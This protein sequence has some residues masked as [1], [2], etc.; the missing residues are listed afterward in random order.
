MLMNVIMIMAVANQFVLI[1]PV[2]S[3]VIAKEDFKSIQSVE[4][5]VWVS[6]SI[7][8][9]PFNNNFVEIYAFI[10]YKFESF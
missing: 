3:S 2:H 8:H 4:Q 1:N 7:S 10:V 5:N 6:D 9:Y